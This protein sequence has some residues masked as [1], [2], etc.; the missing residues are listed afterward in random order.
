[1]VVKI[2]AL[3]NG[4]AVNGLEDKWYYKLCT[5]FSYKACCWNYNFT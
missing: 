1:L 2:F 4:V 5:W 3:A